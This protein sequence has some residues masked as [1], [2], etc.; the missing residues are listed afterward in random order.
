MTISS[1]VAVAKNNVIG[2][3]NKLIWRLPAD[4]Q[5][6]K[7]HTEGCIIITGR[8]NYESIPEKFRP[9]LKRVTIVVTRQKDYKAYGAFVVTSVE[10]AITMARKI[11]EGDKEVFIIG[12]AEIYKQTMDLANKLY[13][14][15][16]H[17]EFE[18]DVHFPEID[19]K[20]WK[21][22]SRISMKADEKNK[23]D[24]DFCLYISWS[25]KNVAPMFDHVVVC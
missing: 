23:Y 2:K 15:E 24:H 6:F 7:K 9:L 22:V 19:K 18:G 4:M 8:K 13:V 5:W 20:K 3:D 21:E 14:T 10:Q 16:I 11:N 1:I 17:H 12:G 25:E